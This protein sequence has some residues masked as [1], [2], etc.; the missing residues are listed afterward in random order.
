[1]SPWLQAPPTM[2]FP[3]MPHVPHFRPLHVWGHPPMDRPL[4]PV[5]P[6]HI[7]PLPSPPPPPPHVWPPQPSPHSSAPPNP[8]FWHSQHHQRQVPNTIPPGAPYF[9]PQLAP[10]RYGSPPVLAAAPGIPP[11][12]ALYKLDS[13]SSV[14]T[15]PIPTA[16]P[17][18]GQSCPPHSHP[19]FDFHPSKESIDAAIG[20]I[21]SKPWQPLPLGL[22]PP[23]LDSVLVELQ[24]QGIQKVPPAACV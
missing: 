19:P 1:M 10:T 18:S 5:W 8:S 11:P 23:A 21:L 13:G 7:A 15:I 12:H 16:P 6:K 3:P 20:D 17:T 9:P 24:R 2:G 22:K 4:M 14:G